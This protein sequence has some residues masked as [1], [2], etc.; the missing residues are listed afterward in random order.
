ME[1]ENNTK[2]FKQEELSEALNTYPN[3]D[4]LVDRYRIIKP[5][6][7][8][9]MAHVYLVEDITKNN[10]LL[11]FKILRNELAADSPNI[12]RFMR[13]VQV[14][15]K[16]NHPN[17]IKIFDIGSLDGLAYYTMEYLDGD[18]LIKKV[19][20]NLEHDSLCQ[21]I[22]DLS[23]GLHAIHQQNVIHRDLKPENIIF[24]K[25]G[26]LR[27]TDLGVARTEIS[28][29]TTR[30]D[31][32]GSAPYIAPE[33]W[34]GETPSVAADLYSLGIVIY[35]MATKQLPFKEKAPAV[36]M[37]A[38]LEKKPQPPIEI[39]KQLPLWLNRTILKLLEKSP[40]ERFK[41]ALDL[42]IFVEQHNENIVRKSY[43][44]SSIESSS[45]NFLS[46]LN[47]SSTLDDIVVNQQVK[48]PLED[49]KNLED[50]KES[51]GFWK[52]ITN[53]LKR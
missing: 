32:V 4:I 20:D 33:M 21:I 10:E 18:S 24:D 23:N 31:V 16:I 53:I 5:L 25:N 42:A 41:S 28:T 34:T 40:R 1:E 9:G 7:S 8:G 44:D 50:Q 48:I 45:Q 43:N 46:Y 29:I 14:S 26:T 47:K 52:K 22:V 19:L 6:G 37:K 11:A 35:F 17:V 12:R 39:N 13:E 27:I 2:E 38:H 30:G 3:G 15:K 51:A 36:L 49:T